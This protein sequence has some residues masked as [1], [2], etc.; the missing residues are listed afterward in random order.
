MSSR[1]ESALLSAILRQD[2]EAFLRKAFHTLSPGQCY[3]PGWHIAAIAYRL[4]QIRRGEIKRLI[5]N[6][7]PRS[8][9]SIA[10][11]VAFPAFVLGHDPTQRIIC[12][13]YSKG[14][15]YKHAN[16]FRAVLNS[17]WYRALFPAT[18]IGPKDSEEEIELTHRGLR[19][20]TS[21]GGTLT[22]RGGQSHY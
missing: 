7:P 1:T 21:V 6:M 16:D 22:G 20:S 19:L 5:I 3:V 17:P 4:E 2:L 11:S 18:R 9:K 13:S 12:A 14:L 15:S 10:A 8:L